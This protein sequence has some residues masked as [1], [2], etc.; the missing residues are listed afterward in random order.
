MAQRWQRTSVWD[1]SGRP[2]EVW[3][4]NDE[5]ELAC[6]VNLGHE[7]GWVYELKQSGKR[8][9]LYPNLAAGKE[10]VAAKCEPSPCEEE[11]RPAVVDAQGYA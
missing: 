6:E 2:L 11:A 5:Y 9:G 3:S 7:G 10:A 4:L 1:N 8:V